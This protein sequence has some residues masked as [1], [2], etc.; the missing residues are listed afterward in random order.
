MELGFKGGDAVGVGGG[1]IERVRDAEDM[2]EDRFLNLPN[3]IS[4][5]RAVS[6]PFIGWYLLSFL[7]C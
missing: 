3:L 7:R 1:Q 4:I 2:N 5:S 6:G